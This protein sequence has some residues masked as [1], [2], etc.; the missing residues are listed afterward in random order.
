[1]VSAHLRTGML[2]P[3]NIDVSKQPSIPNPE[4]GGYSTLHSMSFGTNDGEVLIPRVTPDGRYLNEKQAMEEYDR[5]HRH[6]GI[7]NDPESATAYAEEL[8]ATEA[9]RVG[10]SSSHPKIEALRKTLY[11]LI[12]PN[13]P[14]PVAAHVPLYR[15]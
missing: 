12:P 5:T 13:S 8:G 6:L 15:R 2:V 11:G 14:Q 10:Q 1:M 4:I 7:F 3:G 9:Q